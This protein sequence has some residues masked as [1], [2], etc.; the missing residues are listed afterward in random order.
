M[1]RNEATKQGY[2]ID[3]TCYPNIAYKGLRFDPDECLDVPTVIEEQ[4]IDNLSE[5]LDNA[6]SLS[7]SICVPAALALGLAQQKYKTK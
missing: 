3:D 7:A 4:L 1:T 6:G 2:K 5:V